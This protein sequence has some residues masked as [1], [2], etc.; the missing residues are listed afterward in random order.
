MPDIL[1][2]AII[3]GIAIALVVFYNNMK[4]LRQELKIRERVAALEAVVF[5]EDR[6]PPAVTVRKPRVRK[7]KND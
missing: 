2:F 1:I 3:V 5:K 4:E 6:K 7:V